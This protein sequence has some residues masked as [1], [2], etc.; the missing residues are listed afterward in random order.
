MTLK[1][2]HSKNVFGD[3]GDGSVNSIYHCINAYSKKCELINFFT[4]FGDEKPD[5]YY[6]YKEEYL[7]RDILTKLKQASP[8]T[9]FV[10]IYWDQRGS[11]PSIIQE[12]KGLLDALLINNEEVAQVKMYKQFGI[13]HVFTF[14]HG[15]P[16]DEFRDFDTPV[17][18]D[19]F[20]GGNNFNH[21][22][23][24]LS[25]FRYDLIMR[26]R[27]YNSIVVYG[28]G[29][30]FPT[31]KRVPRHV[32]ARV[33]RSAKVNL[34]TN[35]YDITRYY[36]R[37]LFECMGSGRAHITRYVPGMEKHFENGKHLVWFHSIPQAINAVTNLLR[38]PEKREMIA[39]AGRKLVF[40][41]HSF[42]VRSQQL[43]EIFANLC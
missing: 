26:I 2:F 35:H 31:E 11:I 15:V 40:E 37:R 43:K 20:F 17:T 22:K 14:H 1:I 42:D 33:L 21:N 32:Y 29:W 7:T 8:S 16:V 9:K 13:P 27:K 25:K 36:D 28:M 38:Y 6:F 34:G 19:V 39:A 3:I 23:F 41:Q 30:P 5:I 18:H 10:M 24:P 4:H 12:R